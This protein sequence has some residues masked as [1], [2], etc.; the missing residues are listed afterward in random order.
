MGRLNIGPFTNNEDIFVL[1]SNGESTSFSKSRVE[2]LHD[3]YTVVIADSIPGWYEKL[4]IF[5]YSCR[6]ALGSYCG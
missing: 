2:A 1:R 3:N 4:F 5:I 6:I